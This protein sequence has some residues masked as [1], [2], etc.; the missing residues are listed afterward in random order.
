MTIP[1]QIPGL[2]LLTAVWGLGFVLWIAPEGD[3]AQV[4]ALGVGGT[5]VLLGH[6]V[7]RVWGGR[8]VARGMWLGGTA[9]LGLLFGAGS[10]LLALVFMAVK[11]GLHAH[12]PEFS[13][14]EIAWVWQ[15]IPLWA[16]AGLL[17]GLGGGMLIVNSQ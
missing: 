2:R 11:T 14:A 1:V 12:G 17:A 3:L 9:V 7:Q 4:V 16:G 13:P 5:A 6:L 8:R 15:Q 10:G